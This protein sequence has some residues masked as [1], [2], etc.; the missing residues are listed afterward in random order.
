MEEP[1]AN[2][3]LAEDAA[4]EGVPAHEDAI[5]GA[6]VYEHYRELGRFLVKRLR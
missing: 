3:K 2:A 4:K 5:A 1:D 6:H